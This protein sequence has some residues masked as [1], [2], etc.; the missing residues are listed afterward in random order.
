MK[1]DDTGER[2]FFLFGYEKF[3]GKILEVAEGGV[4]NFG[5]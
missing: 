4:N 1:E 3:W 2:G 5:C